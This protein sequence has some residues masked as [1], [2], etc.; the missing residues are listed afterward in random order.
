MRSS[1]LSQVRSHA[2]QFAYRLDEDLIIDDVNGHKKMELL[3][4]C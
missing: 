4:L 3:E 1:K 2:E